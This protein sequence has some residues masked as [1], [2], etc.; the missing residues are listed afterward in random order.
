MKKVEFILLIKELL[1]TYFVKNIFELMD[2]IFDYALENTKDN[3]AVL[4]IKL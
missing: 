4:L 3:I 2:K 1:T